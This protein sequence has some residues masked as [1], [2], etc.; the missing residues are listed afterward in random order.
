MKTTVTKEYNTFEQ[1]LEPLTLGLI[2]PSVHYEAKVEGDGHK[3]T[4]T[5]ND[6]DA[7]VASALE[8]WRKDC[9]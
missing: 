9:E 1:I 2:T 8:K 3:A 6:K 4:A 5:S 7:A